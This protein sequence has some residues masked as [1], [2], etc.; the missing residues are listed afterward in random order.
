MCDTLQSSG[1][2]DVPETFSNWV[3]DTMN[4]SGPWQQHEDPRSALNCLFRFHLSHLAVDT[5][6]VR[7]YL[8]EQ[9]PVDIWADSIRTQVMPVIEQTHCIA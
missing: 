3:E 7:E 9:D 5:T 8:T 4:E 1:L 6:D 2:G